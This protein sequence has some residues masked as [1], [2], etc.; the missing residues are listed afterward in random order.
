MDACRRLADEHGTR[1]LI[2][3]DDA[4]LATDAALVQLDEIAVRLPAA[5]ICCSWPDGRNW[6]PGC[7]R[8]VTAQA[9]AAGTTYASSSR[10]TTRGR[11]RR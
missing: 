1:V 11:N 9:P 3:V 10:S 7:D 2:A 4:D 6:W 8:P 5:E